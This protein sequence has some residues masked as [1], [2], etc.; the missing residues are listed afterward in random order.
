MCVSDVVACMLRVLF[1]YILWQG[2]VFF[3]LSGTMQDV[4]ITPVPYTTLW[5]QLNRPK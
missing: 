5:F 3:D 1:L 2:V 4:N